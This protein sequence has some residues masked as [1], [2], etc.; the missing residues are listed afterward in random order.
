M[1]KV[2]KS[3]KWGEVLTKWECGL[4]GKIGVHKK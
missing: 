1:W 3:K 2:K 4:E